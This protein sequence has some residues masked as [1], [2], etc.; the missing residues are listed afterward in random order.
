VTKE[1]RVV[2][3]YHEAGHAVAAVT[4]GLDL[5]VAS[6]V[7][8][9]DRLGHVI[10]TV[11]E[12]RDLDYYVRRATMTWC[13][14]L[15]GERHFGA[16]VE[17]LGDDDRDQVAAYGDLVALGSGEAGDFAQWTRSRAM[18]LLAVHFDAI[19]DVALALLEHDV[20]TGDEIRRIVAAAEGSAAV[21]PFCS[22]RP[23]LAVAARL[24]PP[25]AAGR[26]DVKQRDGEQE[27]T[28]DVTA[29][30]KTS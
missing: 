29:P 11:D 22:R 6:I 12:A 25:V 16:R 10:V 2:T 15:A 23:V 18:N 24:A 20:L 14:P 7:P 17:D 28:T 26:P 21:V 1:S 19:A 8:D 13:G 9:G 4:L 3:A 30:A 5:E 27:M